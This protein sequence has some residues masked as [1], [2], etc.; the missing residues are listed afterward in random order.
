MLVGAAR[1]FGV[2]GV[3][4]DVAGE[5]VGGEQGA[6]LGGTGTFLGVQ[7]AELGAGGFGLD[8]YGALTR[9]SAQGGKC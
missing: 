9:N 4:F 3:G 7:S 6:I 2:P 5:L 8:I 1:G